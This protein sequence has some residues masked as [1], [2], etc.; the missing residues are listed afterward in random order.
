MVRKWQKHPLRWSDDEKRVLCKVYPGGERKVVEKALWSIHP[1]WRRK[2]LQWDAIR[3]Q[4]QR[5]GLRM[6]G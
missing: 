6:R 2:R 3:K 4:A 1:P 5:L